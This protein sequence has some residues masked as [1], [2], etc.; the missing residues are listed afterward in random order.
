MKQPFIYPYN[1]A[2]GSAKA[3]ADALGCRRIRLENSRYRPSPANVVINW[4]NSTNPS[5]T[6][7]TDAD[8]WINFPSAVAQASNKLAAFAAM[9]SDG[10]SIPRFT[11]DAEEAYQWDSSV[12]VRHK[13]AGHSGDGCQFIDRDDRELLTGSVSNAPLYVEYIKKQAEYRVHVVGDRIIDLQQ[14]KVRSGSDGNNFQIRSHAN[15]WVFARE[16]VL[17]RYECLMSAVSSVKA[18]GLHFGAVDIIWNEL[19]DKYYVL[20]VNTAPGLE[21]ETVNKYANALRGICNGL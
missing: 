14:K 2:S 4:G 6:A 18:L 17:V 16:G 19:N 21:G 10:I 13:L 3:L 20:E 5:W 12:M 8:S 11:S 1:R 15:G 7:S 9:K